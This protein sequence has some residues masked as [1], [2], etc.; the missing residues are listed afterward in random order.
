MLDSHVHVSDAEFFNRE[1]A[2]AR[3]DKLADRLG[4]GC[5]KWIALLGTRKIGGPA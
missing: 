3:L 1:A 4:G 2:I 5:P